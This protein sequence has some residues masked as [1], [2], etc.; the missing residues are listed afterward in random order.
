[1]GPNAFLCNSLSRNW[2]DKCALSSPTQVM[3]SRQA[4]FKQRIAR[5][6]VAAKTHPKFDRCPEMFTW[7]TRKIWCNKRM[8]LWHSRLS[9][10]KKT[11]MLMLWTTQTWSRCQTS[12]IT[13]NLRKCRKVKNFQNLKVNRNKN[14]W[15]QFGCVELYRIIIM[16][17]DMKVDH[18]YGGACGR[19]DLDCVTAA[20]RWDA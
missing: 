6:E 9:R 1:M 18:Y 4:E 8:Q 15:K 13:K 14:L 17:V 16:R 19:E 12:T 20:L 3:D 7:K 11:Q 10:P 5:E 2:A